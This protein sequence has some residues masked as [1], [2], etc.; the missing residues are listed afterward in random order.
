MIR[1]VVILMLLLPAMI[2]SAATW[3]VEKSGAGDFVV[4]QD[5]INAAASGDTIRIGV[6]WYEEYALYEEPNGE[7]AI[8]ARIPN[9][10]LT[11]LGSGRDSTFIGS[12]K[13][14]TWGNS[15]NC[16]GILLPGNY[17]DG[18]LRL[19]DVSVEGVTRAIEIIG[20]RLD[21]ARIQVGRCYD[22]IATKRPVSV[23]NC[24]FFDCSFAGFLSAYGNSDADIL[25]CDFRNCFMGFN[26]TSSERVS[27]RDCD[28]SNCG[29]TG[30]FWYC[31][32]EMSDCRVGETG[33][34][35]VEVGGSSEF[36]VRNN[37]FQGPHRNLGLRS[38]ADNVTC[39]GNVF[40][41]SV[42]YAIWIGNCSP[43]FRDNEI[44][45]DSGN[46]V[47]FDGPPSGED[48][49]IDMENNYWGTDEPDSIAAW[50]YD[51]NDEPGILHGYVDFDPFLSGNVANQKKTLG[52]IKALFRDSAR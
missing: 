3:S 38:G 16:I 11:I 5:A 36:V 32:G 48:F 6:G 15:D 30:I 44:L 47:V 45:F 40:S 20:G 28:F 13:E 46:S 25:D 42:D 17:R 39:T 43:V 50:I 18:A 37:F 21:C 14:D 31:T 22:G 10:Q 35:G 27:V 7:Y 12:S 23:S 29:S 4:I 24:N 41:G 2:S 49:R 8:Y 19:E 34:A 9:I 51:G 26:F 1:F 52:G 33:V